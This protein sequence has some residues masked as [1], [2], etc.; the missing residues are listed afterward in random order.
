MSV[1][2]FRAASVAVAVAA[3]LLLTACGSSPQDA[4]APSVPTRA[5]TST[6]IPLPVPTEAQL[7]G[8]W[9]VVAMPLQS[10][11]VD[12]R[13]GFVFAAGDAGRTAETSDGCNRQFGGF[14]LGSNGSVALGGLSSTLKLCPPADSDRRHVDA[15]FAARTVGLDDRSGL[16][17]LVFRDET[18]RIV[19]VLQRIPPLSMGALLGTWKVVQLGDGTAPKRPLSVDFQLVGEAGSI[20]TGDGCSSASADVVLSGQYGIRF[21]APAIIT[22]PCSATRDDRL[23]RS[24]TQVRSASADL[25]GDPQQVTLLTRNGDPVAV[26]ER[27]G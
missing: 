25:T 1:R 22:R 16:D 27:A 3:L 13:L 4:P 18:E 14:S 5:A 26:L 9:G 21:G 10:K 15:M 17:Q 12:K 24:L 23:V 8:S 2:R 11:P 19:L 7:L 6:A 20:V